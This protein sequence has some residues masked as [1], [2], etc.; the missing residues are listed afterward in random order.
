MVGK[1]LYYSW[2][3]ADLKQSIWTGRTHTFEPNEKGQR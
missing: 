2:W 3:D 1:H